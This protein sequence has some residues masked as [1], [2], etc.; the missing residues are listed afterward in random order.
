MGVSGSSDSI[1]ELVQLYAEDFGSQ[2]GLTLSMQ[3]PES[4][5]AVMA[6][7]PSEQQPSFTSGMQAISANRFATPASIQMGHSQVLVMFIGQ[8]LMAVDT[9]ASKPQ[10]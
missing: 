7:S 1:L 10:R 3:D 2:S 6:A 8:I 5:K 4:L 9:A